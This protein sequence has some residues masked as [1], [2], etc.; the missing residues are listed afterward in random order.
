MHRLFAAAL[1]LS[2]A[3]P[4]TAAMAQDVGKLAQCAAIARDS[5]RLACYDAA[6]ADA[7]PAAR[8]A[9]AARAKETARIAAEEAAAAAV[10]AK[11]AAAAAEQAKREAFGA[12]TV[13]TRPD[14]F[15]PPPG[16]IQ[17]VEAALVE[18]LSNRSGLG[19]FVLDNGQIWRQ[20]D[21]ASLPNLRPGDKITVERA[22][23]GGYHLTFLKQKRWV[24]V[25]RM[26]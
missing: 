19:V 12:E 2:P 10:A 6:M 22:A 13:T 23:L 24:L 20:V 11:A 14:R 16:E 5:E 9:S 15:Q 21:T 26:R 18:V 3:L 4:P 8:A 25:R 17:T 7:S 1:L